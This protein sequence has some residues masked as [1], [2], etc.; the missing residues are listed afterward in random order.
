VAMTKQSRIENQ[1]DYLN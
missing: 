1:I